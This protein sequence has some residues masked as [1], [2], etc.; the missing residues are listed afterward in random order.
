[1]KR[2]TKHATP[3]TFIALLALIFALTGGAFAATGGAGNGGGKGNKN[4]TQN[5]T[6]S[7]AKAKPK[8]K[9]PARGPAGPKGATGA[10]GPAGPAGATGPAGAAGPGGPVGGV[11]PQGPTG[12]AGEKGANGESVTN[13]ALAPGKG[14]CKEGGA[15]FKVG[16]T[17]THACNGEKGAIHPGETLPANASETGNWVASGPG[18]ENPGVG[19]GTWEPT[20]I[21]FNIP[22]ETAPTY[23]IIRAG[24]PEGSDPTGCSGTVAAP[25]AEPGNLCIF[26]RAEKNVLPDEPGEAGYNTYSPETGQSEAAGKSGMVFGPRPESSEK[27]AFAMGTW[28][29]TAN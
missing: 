17:S 4:N 3:S 7:A 26:V 5:L 2:L 27:D 28:V 18:T 25:A 6:A 20:S 29:V 23:H 9:A 16:A 15:E 10:A 12:A 8:A 13:T 1:M 11:G 21:S 24:T 22:L 14:G 19:F